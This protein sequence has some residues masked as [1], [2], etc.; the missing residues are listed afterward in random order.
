MV[1]L[2]RFVP[3]RATENWLRGCVSVLLASLMLLA[4]VGEA[5]AAAISIVS[6]EEDLATPV[7]D[8]SHGW[9]FQV[10]AAITVTRLGLWDMDGLGL[11]ESHDLGLYRISDGALLTSGTLSAGTVNDLVDGF[12]YIDT[13]DVLLS[14][15]ESYVIAF[16]SSRV[17]V[18]AHECVCVCVRE[19]V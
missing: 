17:R 12:R 4:P 8:S 19:C 16:H 7:E 9:E 15:S 18:C 2:K 10:N 6:Y 5:L 11:F 14:T 1:S 3:I 13:V